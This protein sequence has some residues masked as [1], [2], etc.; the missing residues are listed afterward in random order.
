MA[1]HGNI[2]IEPPLLLAIE[3]TCQHG[4][5]ALV[6]ASSCLAEIS[7]LS[8]Q[9][10]SKRLLTAI[11]R[12]FAETELGW[13]SVE[14]IAISIGPGSFTGLRIG[15]AT[16]KGLAMATGKPLIGVPTLDGLAH[17]LV[18]Q[19]GPVCPV[20]DARKQEI[21][22]AL[23]RPDG[24]GGQQ[25]ITEYL[26]VPPEHL[27]ELLTEP[28][29]LVGDGLSVYG[30]ILAGLLGERAIF[31]PPTLYFPRAAAI[32]SLAVDQYR[33]G[34]FLDAASCAPIYI[35]ASDAEQN[36]ARRKKT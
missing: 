17:Q 14:A 21:F 5:V 13:D 20:M 10:H 8:R 36:L 29:V 4:S 31:A 35:R 28:T 27:D 6:C 3:N 19:P 16:V 25:R 11:D 30:E 33:K 24:H 15:L 12:L 26:A 22:T 34:D 9:T 18:L 7:L 2:T 23:Y 1:R 32:G